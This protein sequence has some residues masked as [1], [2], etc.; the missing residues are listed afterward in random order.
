V[1][2]ASV[3][4]SPP[5]GPILAIVLAAGA[6]KRMGC[7]K[8]LVKLGGMSFLERIAHTL[9]EAGLRRRLVVLAGPAGTNGV[10]AVPDLAVPEG[11]AIVRNMHPESGMLSSVAAALS[12]RHALG[13]AAALIWPVDC[14]RVPAA[15]VRALVER[16]RAVGSGSR[17]AVVLPAYGGRRGHPVLFSAA[18][19]GVLLAAPP[20]VGAREVLRAH[21]AEILEV[22]VGSP[23]ILDDLDTPDD[24]AR[25]D[26]PGAP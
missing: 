7:P 17:N 9:G 8:A 5:D 2:A 19:F 22:E 26:T 14:P 10:P 6:G 4:G 16:F 21:A 18:L 15:V 3:A 20:G 12:S 24:L 23:E 11:L 1:K 13:A 25:L